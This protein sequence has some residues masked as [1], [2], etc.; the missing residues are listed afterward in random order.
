MTLETKNLYEPLKAGKYRAVIYLG[1]G[2]ELYAEFDA[3]N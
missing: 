2:T 1:D 3:V